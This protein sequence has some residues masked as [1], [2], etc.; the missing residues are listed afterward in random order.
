M[1]YVHKG[2]VL[3]NGNVDDGLHMDEL[4]SRWYRGK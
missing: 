4:V 3:E 1:G 2:K